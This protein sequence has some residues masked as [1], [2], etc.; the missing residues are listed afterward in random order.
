MYARVCMCGISCTGNVWGA[1]QSGKWFEA[2]HR[3]RLKVLLLLRPPQGQGGPEPETFP[4]RP[5]CP[6]VSWPPACSDGNPGQKAARHC[7]HTSSQTENRS[8]RTRSKDER[9]RARERARIE[10]AKR[11]PQL[12]S[13]SLRPGRSA[14]RG[15]AQ[16]TAPHVLTQHTQHTQATGAQGLG[17]L[18]TVQPVH[19]HTLISKITKIK[20]KARRKQKEIY[21]IRRDPI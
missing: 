9:A 16:R 11:R 17:R 6:L 21:H 7:T 12:L 14:Q 3:A 19:M 8:G 2:K 10:E 18:G 1:W 20:A 15:R 5:D 4:R 13:Y